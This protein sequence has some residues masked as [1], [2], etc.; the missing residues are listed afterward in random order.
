MHNPKLAILD[1]PISRLDV[2]NS[3]EVRNQ[4]IEY[5]RKGTTV[6]LS[7]HNMLAI[8]FLSDRVAFIHQGKIIESGTPVR[9]R[10]KHN[11]ENLEQVFVKSINR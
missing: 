10:E 9:L 2:I 6:M 8:E 5:A 11:A 3:L 1:E 7:S 4:I